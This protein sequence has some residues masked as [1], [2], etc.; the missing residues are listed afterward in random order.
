[1]RTEVEEHRSIAARLRQAG[2]A[3]RGVVLAHDTEVGHAAAVDRPQRAQE[4]RGSRV[5]GRTTAKERSGHGLE[6]VEVRR[7]AI[8]ARC[9]GIR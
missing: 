2:A 4:P 5:E 9:V 3:A 1:M 8:P 7:D 6:H